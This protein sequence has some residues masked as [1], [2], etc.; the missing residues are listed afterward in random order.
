MRDGEIDA[1]GQLPAGPVQGMQAGAATV[2]LAS[3]LLDDHFGIGINV[4]SLGVYRDGVLQSFEEG[5]VL[6]DV[7]V[8]VSDPLGDTDDFA[9]RSFNY[10]ANSGWSGIPMGSAVD[11]RYQ[12]GHSTPKHQDALLRQVRQAIDVARIVLVGYF[13]SVKNMCARFG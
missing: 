6:G 5:N 2:V 1:S 7:V 13:V 8:L 10:D 11:V 4:Q 9:V 12:I 3:H